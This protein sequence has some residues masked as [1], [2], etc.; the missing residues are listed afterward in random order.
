VPLD[1]RTYRD[2]SKGTTTNT[3]SSS[4]SSSA[5]QLSGFEEIL[6]GRSKDRADD[7]I[8]FDDAEFVAF[9]NRRTDYAPLA[10]VVIPRRYFPHVRPHS[11]S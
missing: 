7:R 5:L 10:A 8:L 2:V 4:S 11:F 9:R 6:R 3:S 1:R